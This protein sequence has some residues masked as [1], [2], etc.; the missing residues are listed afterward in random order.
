MSGNIFQL[1]VKHGALSENAQTPKGEKRSC[2]KIY[3]SPLTAGAVEQGADSG[4]RLAKPSERITVL[5]VT[6]VV[7]WRCGGTSRSCSRPRRMSNIAK[8]EAA[9]EQ[10]GG[11]RESPGSLRHSACEDAHPY[12][13]ILD[14]AQRGCD[15][16][17]MGSHGRRYSWLAA[18]SETQKI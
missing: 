8:R 7:G 3:W 13:A 6:P 9:P 5:T 11:H 12:K 10:I 18:R 1:A 4:D 2:T 16:I 14:T 17:V 15:L